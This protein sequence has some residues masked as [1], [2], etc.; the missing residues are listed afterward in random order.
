MTISLTS[1]VTGAAI[2]GLT[3]PTYTLTKD[4][5][6]SMYGVQHVVS[7]L[8][9]TQTGVV[10]HSV[11]R[12]FTI[13]ATRP[14]VLKTITYNNSGTVKAVPTNTT[15]LLVRKDVVC[16]LAATIHKVGDISISANIPAGAETYDAPSINALFSA[17]I[18][19][20]VQVQQGFV[21]TVKS[22]VI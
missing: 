18:G 12:P 3:S 20:L 21:D 1:P 7:A 9:G 10:P 6:P 13:T 15:K 5:A 14:P 4:V 19:A 22:G 16:D 8:G 17:A 11:G 2:S